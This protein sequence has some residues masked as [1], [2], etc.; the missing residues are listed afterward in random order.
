SAHPERRF[1]CAGNAN[2][3]TCVRHDLC[4]L[5]RQDRGV[6]PV[7]P[8]AMLARARDQ[9]PD[10]QINGAALFY[11]R[12]EVAKR[13]LRDATLGS[14]VLAKAPEGAIAMVVAVTPVAVHVLGSY[15]PNKPLVPM[16]VL[17]VGSYLASARRRLA[18]VDL[19]ITT[20]E[21]Q[22]LAVET[23]RWG[24]NRGNPAVV[25]LILARA[26]S[27]PSSHH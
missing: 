12:G 19:T 1:G 15:G 23:K 27:A 6:V 16:S 11:A 4:G 20:S 21:G 14:T 3:R 26:N 22:E 8:K 7:G 10:E 25:K 2:H 24:A 18:V 17:P 9:L 13:M 5:M